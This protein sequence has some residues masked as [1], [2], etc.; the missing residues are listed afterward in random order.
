MFCRVRPLLG[1]EITSNEDPTMISHMNFPDD[2]GKVVE[3]EKL[4]DANPNEVGSS[5]YEGIINYV[6]LLILESHLNELTYKFALS[7]AAELSSIVYYS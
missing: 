7:F 1:D 4:N 6:D 2:D 5:A 3:L